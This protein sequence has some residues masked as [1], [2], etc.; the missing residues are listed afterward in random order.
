M[1]TRTPE[2]VG[3][4][5]GETEARDERS[6][7]LESPPRPETRGGYTAD[8]ATPVLIVVPSQRHSVFTVTTAK[9]SAK[10]RSRSCDGTAADSE[11][12]TDCNRPRIRP[13]ESDDE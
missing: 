5:R 9:Q 10:A 8:G 11:A 1:S 3:T 6:R 4:G 7:R 13:Q 2:P 12:R